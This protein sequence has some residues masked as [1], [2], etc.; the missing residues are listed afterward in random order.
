MRS[1]N[2]NITARQLTPATGNDNC[3]APDYRA[4]Y[5]AA[6]EPARPSHGPA[7]SR[8][9]TASTGTVRTR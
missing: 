1:V 2:G 4:D 8:A 6:P 7:P 5:G 3:I 9:A